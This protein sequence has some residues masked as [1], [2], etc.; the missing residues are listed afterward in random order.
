MLS[1]FK[2]SVISLSNAIDSVIKNNIDISR[3]TSSIKALYDF[4]TKRNEYLQKNIQ[5]AFKNFKTK[6]YALTGLHDDKSEPIVTSIIG[7]VNMTEDYYKNKNLEGMKEAVEQIKNLADELPEQTIQRQNL[8]E[9]MSVS[10]NAKIPDEIKD[11]IK[12]DI[13]EMQKCFNAKCYRSAIILCG[14]ILETALHRKYYDVTK[15]DILETSPGIGLGNLI[16]K[17]TEAKV[18]FDP[19]ITQQIHLINQVRVF[20]VHKKQTAFRPS[21]EQAQAVILYTIDVLKKLF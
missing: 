4:K 16:A 3:T 13:E 2:K 14:R 20:S 10:F 18:E 9:N 21:K 11:E 7:L 19:G 6:S 8:S 15:K 5:T 17:L 12:T 1:E